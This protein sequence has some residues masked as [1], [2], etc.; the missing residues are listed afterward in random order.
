MTRCALALHDGEY[1]QAHAPVTD[2]DTHTCYSAVHAMR[3]VVLRHS[4]TG[5]GLN[6]EKT[7]QGPFVIT[8]VVE[9]K[10]AALGGEIK[11]NDLL[12]AVDTTSLYDLD[13]AQ[14]KA[15]VAGTP[16]QLGTNV[17]LWIQAAPNGSGTPIQAQ[18][19]A[20]LKNDKDAL[21][22]ELANLKAEFKALQLLFVTSQA[23]L[24]RLKGK[25]TGEAVLTAT[26]ED[27][28]QRLQQEAAEHLRA[29][30][31]HRKALRRLQ[32]AARNPELNKPVS[33]SDAASAATLSRKTQDLVQ[34]LQHLH[35]DLAQG[36][37]HLHDDALDE[38]LVSELATDAKNLWLLRRQI[39]ADPQAF[40]AQA[41]TSQDGSLDRN[42]W[43]QACA[44]V[45]GHAAPDLANALF[46]MMDFDKSGHV[47][48]GE[49]VE[50]RR[51]VR[52][53]VM[54]AGFQELAVE[55]L[56]GLVYG[57]L[58][59]NA[60]AE[61]GT[62][63]AEQTLDTLTELSLEEM[64]GDVAP[65]YASLKEHGEQVKQDR[66]AR[67]KKLAAFEVE[68]AEGKFTQLPTAAYGDKDS[69]H[70]GLEV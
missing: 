15:L 40:F 9:G 8:A 36:L 29:V 64:R 56:S 4:P 68:E 24:D 6:I 42:E 55:S 2:T 35:D 22:A 58:S 11:V 25:D 67:A 48:M 62:S 27:E 43:A 23:E 65:L 18:V 66:E 7:G 10:A 44:G 5:L 47:S 17:A 30:K 28:I 53:F 46:D 51:A 69:F 59:K 19:L 52:L 21:H 31:E 70:K 60:P 63:L 37:Q 61:E 45:L 41:D 50:I 12:H 14:T 20:K 26:D 1:A 3:R 38:A 34:G 13:E 32:H 33:A 39:A 57:H 49:F 54:Q 16:S